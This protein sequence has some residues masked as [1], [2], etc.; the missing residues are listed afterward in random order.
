VKQPKKPAAAP[1]PI[2]LTDGEVQLMQPYLARAASASQAFQSAQES[3]NSIARTVAGRAGA[4][5]EQRFKLD[6]AG[7]RLIPI[8]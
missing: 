8:Q 5:P 7:K 4:L 3:L 1:Q 2:Q 6:I